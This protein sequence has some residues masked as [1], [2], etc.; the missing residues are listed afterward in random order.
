MKKRFVICALFL[1]GGAASVPAA[2]PLPAV[3]ARSD[4]ISVSG[5][6]SGGYMAVQFQVAFSR[7]VKGVGVL[8]AGPYDCAEGSAWR[9]LNNCMSP[10]S[11]TPPPTPEAVRPR[12]ESRARL[13]LIDPPGGLADDRA[14][15]LTGSSDHTVE[16]PVVDALVA[17]YRQWM[18]AGSIR[19][20]ALPDAG[21]AMIS[22][23]DEHPNACPTSEPPYINRCG[24]FDAPGELLNY[25]LGPLKP[26]SAAR[27]ESLVAFD[28]RPFIEGQPVDASLAEE[29][30]AY[31]PAR[32]RTGGCQVHVAF[33]G[34]RQGEDQIGRRFVEGAGYN[35][36]AEGNG[37]VV[38]YP[39]TV[40]R[41]GLAIGSLRWVYNPKGCWDWWGYSSVDYATRNG[42]Q[43]AA[44]RRMVAR[45]MDP[46]G[47]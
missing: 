18:P 26:K 46:A 15:V 33:H 19:L 17:F 23:A 16:R 36:W 42:P 8:A 32:C 34:C 40:V 3:G 38:L 12:M 20:V 14:W 24:D 41:N 31:I 1:A 47:R 11:W 25:V 7:L 27:P 29:G 43:M 39:Q 45:L 30:Y 13:G 22:I 37:L 6:S 4:G 35:A 21:H 5:I 9:A 28:Q 44:V 2:S 10:G